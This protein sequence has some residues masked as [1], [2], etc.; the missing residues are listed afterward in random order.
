MQ[1][2]FDKDTDNIRV[3]NILLHII[4][5]NLN[6]LYYNCYKECESLRNRI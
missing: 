5:Y 4:I 3:L 2:K 1:H 6:N